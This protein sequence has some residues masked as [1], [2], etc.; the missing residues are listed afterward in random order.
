MC[1]ASHHSLMGARPG[2]LPATAVCG[3]V[4]LA[5]QAVVYATVWLWVVG[6]YTAGE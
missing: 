4:T 3:H 2:T 6:Q 5:P 1:G